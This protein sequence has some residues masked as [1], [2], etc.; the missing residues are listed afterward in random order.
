MTT[1]VGA[2]GR[3]ITDFEFTIGTEAS[4][5]IQ[6]GIQAK[7]R[8][9]DVAGRVGFR[10]YVT[11]SATGNAVRAAPSGGLANGNNDDG[12]F[13]HEDVPDRVASCASDTDG[14]FEV[15]ITHNQAATMYLAVIGADGR[16][17]I[18]PAITFA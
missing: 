2:S 5:V 14:N 17:T 3:N 18:S 13:I 12:F 10:L 8:G 1:I 15:T 9:E 4:N 7:F 11:S 16:I 6:V